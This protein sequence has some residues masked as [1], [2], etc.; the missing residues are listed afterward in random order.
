MQDKYSAL[1]VSHSSISDFL[2]CPRSYYLKNVY[3]DPKT[4]SK[5]K[6]ISPAL[7]L[8][9][10]V[11]SVLESLSVLPVEERFSTSLINKFDD[12]WEKYSGKKGGFFSDD[13][14][15]KYKERG[16]N[17]IKRVIDNPGPL[18]NRAIKINMDLPFYW[19]SEQDNIILC[20]KID[21]LEYLEESDS[22]N[23]IDFK[24]GAKKESED[25]LQLPIYHLLVKNCQ[26]RAV[27]SA[28]YWYLESENKPEK[29]DLPDLE[30]SFEEVYK[31]A[32][33]IKVAKQ[34]DALECPNGE[35]GCPYCRFY[36]AILRGEG[37]LIGKDG[38]GADV[39]ILKSEH[40]EEDR[41]GRLL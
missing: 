33:K 24:T 14:E 28:S 27:S 41:E 29:V 20:G 25:S 34:L 26:N 15:R 19:L 4:K 39:Y 21:W 30:T 13:L 5:I 40:V 7:S 9:S 10:A 37:E 2:A 6:L 23:I 35:E 32:K 22:V 12:E 17:M 3:K 38:F 8:G 16:E 31:I 18:K 11:H 1:W 36:E